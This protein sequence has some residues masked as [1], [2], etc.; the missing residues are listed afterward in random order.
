MGVV[1]AQAP[2][3][4]KK[5]KDQ[6]E[7]DLFTE[8]GKTNDPQKRLSL[9]NTWKEKYPDTAFKE[10]RLKY[11]LGTYQQL[12]QGA[13]MVETA[14]EIIV[15]NPKEVNA[16]YWLTLLT[17]TMPATPDS[18]A[19]G[20]KAA[21]ALLDAPKPEGVKDEDWAKIKTQMNLTGVAHN[22]LAFIANQK[23]DLDTAEKEY[24]K[25]LE[26]NPNQADVSYALGNTILA[27]K[28]P[29]RQSEVLFHWARAA[30]LKGPGA[31]PPD[32]LKTVEAFFTKQYNAFHGSDEGLKELRALATGARPTPPEG[33]KIKNKV[34]IENE[35]LEKAAKENPQLTLWKTIK[36]QLTGANGE[37][38]FESQVKGAGLPGGAN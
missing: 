1:A 2:T 28:K 30:S 6:G 21:Q 32:K 18:L 4:E 11:Y 10:E 16:L 9:L 24:M 37:Q 36:D 23:K 3:A 38:Y 8:V 22:T 12:N 27:Q 35:N 5:V 20:E 15:I 29:E 14:K 7:Y 19:T 31:I 13:K 17:Q 25:S 33:F 26:A 34:E